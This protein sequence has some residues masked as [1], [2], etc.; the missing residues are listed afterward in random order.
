MPQ[1]CRGTRAGFRVCKGD[2]GVNICLVIILFAFVCKPQ[3]PIEDRLHIPKTLP[4]HRFRTTVSREALLS[5]SIIEPRERQPRKHLM[6]RAP[7]VF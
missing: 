7:T 1:H 2:R 5:S 6:I 4:K 3:Q